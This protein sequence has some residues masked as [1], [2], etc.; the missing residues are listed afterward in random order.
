MIPSIKVNLTQFNNTLRRAIQESSRT[1]PEVINGHALGVANQAILLT[2]KANKSEMERILGQIGRA[3][4]L[5][6][7]GKVKKRGYGKRIIAEDSFAARIVNARRRDFAGPDYMLWGTALEEAARKLISARARTVA[8]IKSGWIWA[9]RDLIAV[10][11][12][13]RRTSPD[14][15]ARINQVRKGKAIPARGGSSGTFKATIE[16]S[17]LIASGGKFQAKG[18]HSPMPIAE[19]GLNAAL[20]AELRNMEK[21]LRDKMTGAMK[22]AGAM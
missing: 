3:A 13:G 18:P 4:N 5:T 1:A 16:N 10:V 17:S 15:D 6:K 9:L 14:K 21:H 19:R 11:K 12:G 8:F 22:R 7:S 20:N 2:E